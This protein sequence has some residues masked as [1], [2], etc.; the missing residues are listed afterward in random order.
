MI[1]GNGMM[2]WFDR[3]EKYLGNW[4]RNLEN[5]LGLHVW[6]EHKSEARFIRNRYLGEWHNGRRNGYGIFYYSNGAVYEGFFHDNKKNGFGIHYTA[7]G[8]ILK[9]KFEND[10]F[11]NK[12][13]GMLYEQTERS[14]AIKDSP[15]RS[16][17][18]V[19][20]GNVR[21]ENDGSLQR[22]N[23]SQN[24]ERIDSEVKML[25]KKSNIVI[26]NDAKKDAENNPFKFSIDLNDL[27]ENQSKVREAGEL[28]EKALLRY[29]AEMRLWYKIYSVKEISDFPQ[30]SHSK[31]GGFGRTNT[32]EDKTPKVLNIEMDEV[33]THNDVC[34]GMEMRDM[35]RFLRE[36][37]LIDR[38]FLICH[39]NRLFANSQS[40][41]I[42][43]LFT[44]IDCTPDEYYKEVKNLVLTQKN[45]FLAD[46]HEDVFDEPSEDELIP[47]QLDIHDYRQVVLP[48]QFYESLVRV[49]LMKHPNCDLALD[50]RF[51]ELIEGAKRFNKNIP[52]KSKN[53]QGDISQMSA[54]KSDDKN[55]KNI[56]ASNNSLVN[57]VNDK[58]GELLTVF[59]KIALVNEFKNDVGDLTVK[60]RTLYECLIQTEMFV[61]LPKKI[62]VEVA[63]QFMRESVDIDILTVAEIF[64]CECIFYEFM[65]ILYFLIRNV[66]SNKSKNTFGEFFEEN[67]DIKR[68]IKELKAISPKMAVV[69]NKR[70]LVIYPKLQ[71]HAIH[72]KLIEVE[73]RRENERMKRQKEEERRLY[74]N[75]NF[76][77]E[78][79]N[80]L[81]EVVEVEEEEEEFDE[82]GDNY[83]D[84]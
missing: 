54:N 20:A 26:S 84:Y 58:A 83:Y 72:E 31:Y 36:C 41:K 14:K 38:N 74:E 76:E 35:W 4:E 22:V 37:G 46:F 62:F 81:P 16:N 7:E 6:F 24:R 56:K 63:T 52:S 67:D 5:G 78:D 79:Y 49:T 44:R 1:C 64:E 66:S 51:K 80:V 70:T 42:N 59:R 15:N 25:A 3:F 65:E 75:E 33:R 39:F 68:I 28:I 69:R 8:R 48:R 40:N 71:T 73:L 29:L 32:E 60:Y 34:Q 30:E 82:N 61:D 43:Y 12:N 50:Q 11:C 77:F 18:R 55:R 9:G 13:A 2:T 53:S 27:L 45:K 57:F 21:V 47:I 17:R 19:A 10:I 23:L